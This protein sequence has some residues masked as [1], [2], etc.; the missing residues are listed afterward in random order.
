MKRTIFSVVAVA[1]SLIVAFF[2]GTRYG[3][4]CQAAS[5]T[6]ISP[7]AGSVFSVDR[8]EPVKPLEW[9]EGRKETN[10]GIFQFVCAKGGKYWLIMSSW[11]EQMV[12]KVV[13]VKKS[14][15][16]RM[17]GCNFCGAVTDSEGKTHWDGLIHYFLDQDWDPIKNPLPI[18]ID[19]E[20]MLIAD[21]LSV[22]RKISPRGRGGK[23]NPLIPNP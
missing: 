16:G 22:S 12:P 21:S 20:P 6:P 4:N 13:F 18:E 8:K 14:G 7:L 19:I 11:D 15:G 23:P 17:C 1:L 10:D 5:D 9:D 2:L 3:S